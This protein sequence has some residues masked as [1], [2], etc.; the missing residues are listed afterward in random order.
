MKLVLLG[1]GSPE[2]YAP[3]ASAGYL[4]DFGHQRIQLDCGG[5]TFDRLLQAGYAPGDVNALFLTHLHSDHMMDY[6][7]LVHARWDRSAG[8]VPELEVYAP[9]PMAEISEKYFGEDGV[10][11]LD[12]T[13]RC[14]HPASQEIFEMRGGQ[15]P[16]QWPNP[17]VTEIS[18]GF[19]H[20]GDGWRLTAISVPHAQPFLI[21]L[22]YRVDAGGQSV[23]YSGDAGP[24]MALNRI[25][26]GADVLVH[27][28]FQMSEEVLK[29]EWKRGSAGHLEVAQA[30]AEAGVRKLVLSHLRESM[31]TEETHRRLLTEVGEIYKGEIVIAQDLLEIE[32]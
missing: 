9:A 16:R 29:P 25:A 14:E 15:L 10:F 26:E 27:M 32:L 17:S 3:R 6:A 13:A 8:Q 24:S 23:V 31:D 19:T 30:G 22:A 1:T 28:C 18:S 12:L 7:R 4:I 11:A 20:E 5:G 21:S 2:P